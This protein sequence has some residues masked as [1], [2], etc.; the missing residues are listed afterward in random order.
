MVLCIIRISSFVQW[1]VTKAF[2]RN[3]MILVA[4]WKDFAG[5]SLE[6]GLEELKLETRIQSKDFLGNWLRCI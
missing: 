6:N 3:Y 1:K 5:S 4:V 2:Q